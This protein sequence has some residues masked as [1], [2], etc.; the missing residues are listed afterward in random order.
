MNKLLMMLMLLC[1]AA[2]LVA[3]IPPPW[4]W[5]TRA[6]GSGQDGATAIVCDASGN[7]YVAGWFTG[8]IQL[9]DFF[10]DSGG[11]KEIFIAKLD[12][13]G[14]YLWA[15]RCGGILTDEVTDMAIDSAG[16][17]YITGGFMDVMTAG[18]LGAVSE[19]Q[20]DIFVAKLSSAGEW[21]WVTS[22][23]GEKSDSGRCLT[24][25]PN[26][27]CFVAGV[28]QE[29]AFFAGHEITSEQVDRVFVAETDTDGNWIL[30]TQGGSEEYGDWE[31]LQDIAVDS[32]GNCYLAGY[33]DHDNWPVSEQPKTREVY[34]SFVAKISDGAWQWV[35]QANCETF[36][37]AF[38]ITV[39]SAGNLYVVG[40]FIGVAD[41]SGTTLTSYGD[42]DIYLAKLSPAGNWIWA[43]QAGGTGWDCAYGVTLDPSGMLYVTGQMRGSVT[44]GPHLY[45]SGNIVGTVFVAKADLEGNWLWAARAVSWASATGTSVAADQTGRS[46]V[47]GSFTEGVDFGAVELNSSGSGDIFIAGLAAVPVPIDDPAAENTPD[48]TLVLSPNPALTGDLLQFNLSLPLGV[49][50]ELRIYNQRGQLVSSHSAGPGTSE[51][52]LDSHGLKPGI[53]LCRLQSGKKTQVQKLVLMP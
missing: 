18:P 44:F 35:T 4:L 15:R 22:A 34:D 41:F 21:L 45:P 39:D 9:G 20:D 27:H 32:D 38:G 10:T 53:Y 26:G 43:V 16:N 48:C 23:G 5:A 31:S 17:V 52:S 50:V 46:F 19:G 11:D 51:F 49:G 1:V 37:Q 25:A 13:Q 12:A 33:D 3:Q 40:S 14:N 36:D 28:Y 7:I 47:C 30:V 8:Y 24:V 29:K 42:Q 2:G 6:G